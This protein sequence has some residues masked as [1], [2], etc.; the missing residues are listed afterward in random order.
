MSEHAESR[1][2]TSEMEKLKPR[3]KGTSL[4]SHS[5]PAAAW[6]TKSAAP[7]LPSPH[8]WLAP[9]QPSSSALESRSTVCSRRGGWR[10]EG[11][12]RIVC[13]EERKGGEGAIL[14]EKMG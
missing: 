2:F 7:G 11:W 5:Q 12:V 14:E 9:S 3:E 1:S 4:R 8:G 10:G 6:D 13:G